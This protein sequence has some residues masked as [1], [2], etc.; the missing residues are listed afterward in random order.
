M[1]NMGGVHRGGTRA[2]RRWNRRPG[3]SASALLT[4]A[5]LAAACASPAPTPAPS[6]GASPAAGT[7]SLATSAGATPSPTPTAPSGEAWSK[8]V[9]DDIAPVAS[10]EPTASGPGGIATTATFRLTSLD[11]TAPADLAARLRVDP[12]VTLAVASVDGPAAVLR[13]ASALRPSTLYR[14]SLLG[15]D[16]LVAASWAAQTAGPLHLAESIPGDGATGVPQDAGIELDFDQPGVT[17]SDLQA[18][19]RIVPATTGT[20]EATGRQLAFVPSS[21]LRRATLYTVTLTKGLPIAGT[22]Q[23]LEA[24]TTFRFETAGKVASD[25][26]IGPVRDFLE[27]T[28]RDPAAMALWVDNPDDPP[29]P[30]PARVPVTVHRLAGL[31]RAEAAWR[32]L[33]TTPTWTRVTT[34]PAVT[35]GG[36]AKVVDARLPIRGSDGGWW[37]RLPRPLAAGWYVVT[38]AWGGVPHQAVLQVTDLA[39][40]AMVTSTRTAVWLHDMRTASPI[41]GATVVA[42]GARLGRT[43]SRGLLTA[44]TPAALSTLAV[45]DPARL[46]EVRAGGRAA[47]QPVTADAC[48]ACADDVAG[49]GWWHLLTSDRTL[50]RA[51]DTVNAWGVVRDRA[52]GRVPASLHVT[53]VATMAGSTGAPPISAQD[54]TPDARGA[55]SVAVPLH[56]LPAGAYRLRVQAGTAQVGELWFD[57]GTITKPAYRLAVTTDRPAITSGDPLAVSVH[58][59]FFEGTPVAGTTLTLTSDNQPDAQVTTNADGDGTASQPFVIAT[60]EEWTVQS[61]QAT[62]TAPEEAA[63]SGS[64]DVAVFRGSILVDATGSVAARRLTVTGRV[65]GVDLSRFDGVA[66]PDL[67]SVDPHGA[68]R[69]GARVTVKVIA[70][71]SSTRRIGSKYDFVLK[72]V[73]PIYEGKDRQATVATRTVVTGRD[74]TFRLELPVSTADRSYEVVATSSDGAGRAISTSTYA[75]GAEQASQGEFPNLVAPGTQDL[76]AYSVG[77]AVRVRFSGGIAKPRVASYLF[78]VLKHGLASVTVQDGPTFRTWFTASSVPAMDIVGVRFTG[79]GYEATYPWTGAL[80]LADRTLSVDVTADRAGYAPGDT[81]TVTVRTKNAAGHP[82]AASVFVQAVD[83]KLFAT[84]DASLVNP[85]FALYQN[86]PDGL[87]GQVRSHQTPDDDIGDGKG[88]GDTTGGGGND[89]RTEF[90]DWLVGRL[91]ETDASG[92]ASLAVPLSDDLTSWHVTAEAFDAALEAGAG[93]HLLPVALPMFAEATIPATLLV[94]DHPVIRVRAFGGGLRAGDPVTFTVSSDTLPMLA[95]TTQAPAFGAAEVPLP[96]LTAGEHRIRIEATAGSLHDTL[97]RTVQ[98]VTSRAA[99]DLTTWSPLQGRTTVQPG[100]GMTQLLLVDGGR[101]RVVPVLE[102]LAGS[103]TARSDLAVAAGVAD[104]TL[105]S[106][107]GLPA[108]PADAEPDL[109]QFHLD[110]GLLALVPWGS[111]DLDASALAAM[112]RDP[113]LDPAG[114]RDGLTTVLNDPSETRDRRLLA[115]AGLSG[116]GEPVL[117]DVRAAAATTD[118]TVPERVSVALAA[119][120]AGDEGLARTIEHRLLSEDGS[121]LGPWTRLDPGAFADPSV[122]TARL[123]IVAASLGEPVAAEMDAWVAANPPTATTVALER[124]LAARGWV[125]RVPAATGVARLSVDGTARDVTV[126]QGAA[127]AVDLTPAQAA[128]AVIEPVSGSVLVVTT[129]SVS[130]ASAPLTPPAGQTL[131]RTVDPAGPVGEAG[132]VRVTLKVDLGDK[133]GDACWRLV[134]LVPS[135]LAPVGEGWTDDQGTIVGPDRI[136]GQRVEFCVTDDPKTPVQSLSYIARVV[137]PGTYAWEPA[138]LQSSVAPDQGVVTPATTVTI[139]GSGG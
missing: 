47:F 83:E 117:A 131:D 25:V 89:G 38:I 40:Y 71:W 136:D 28:P 15:T 16:G 84:G 81:A 87:I 30:M 62:P 55:F 29:A 5:A 138:V 66:V 10:L 108:T 125:G 127:T 94:D 44:R 93:E 73:V 37:L 134:D 39:P 76:P 111:A 58:G 31:D 46:L 114:L 7:A 70:H 20:I 24:D 80:R 18:H 90:R 50:Y 105:A 12:P 88:G 65:T 112:S 126:G 1:D 74:G 91:I 68:P 43:D 54:V 48:G 53:L 99:R 61:I 128:S 23:G 34:T 118:L 72:R 119:L 8:V 96:A 100:Q 2:A 109:D 78:A 35:T 122:E 41:A 107:F 79:Y 45:N 135:G 110:E 101:G 56:D 64:T 49:G 11:G 116:L 6:A 132:T 17:A 97:V 4:I 22:G 33:S 42:G 67:S 52:T 129:T 139:A 92:T 115:L 14:F 120:Y 59:S 137:D 19:L 51:S 104:A 130:L 95:V 82:V 103:G 57:V 113:R 69:A 102:D 75:A 124:A 26:A 106:Q 3:R 36:L 86:L 27:A 121:H 85:I 77:D 13:P 98:V 133:A 21:P 63:I 60:D 9:V 32:T 123:A